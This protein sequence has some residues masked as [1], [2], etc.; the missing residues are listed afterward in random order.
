VRVDRAWLFCCSFASYPVFCSPAQLSGRFAQAGCSF[1]TIQRPRSPPPLARRHDYHQP[2]S[3]H[4]EITSLSQIAAHPG[5]GMSATVL[6]PSDGTGFINKIHFFCR[7]YASVNISRHDLTNASYS[8]GGPAITVNG[9]AV[10]QRLRI[11]NNR[12]T[13]QTPALSEV[14][15]CLRPVQIRGNASSPITAEKR[16]GIGVGGAIYIYTNSDVLIRNTVSRN[17]QAIGGPKAS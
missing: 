2:T 5:K 1:T 14:R 4:I 17:N 16:D 8:G 6:Q 11:T 12:D 15:F 7:R 10:L 3:L 9:W 13:P